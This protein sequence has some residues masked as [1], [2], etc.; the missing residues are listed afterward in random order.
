MGNVRIAVGNPALTGG[1]PELCLGYPSLN[2][3]TTVRDAQAS[4]RAGCALLA[5]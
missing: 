3:P 5:R 4:V 1:P 2:Q